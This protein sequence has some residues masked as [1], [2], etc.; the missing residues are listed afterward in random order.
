MCLLFH[1][2]TSWR[3]AHPWLHAL[4]YFAWCAV[5]TVSCILLIQ[6]VWR[7]SVLP[8]CPSAS[9]LSFSGAAYAWSTL[10]VIQRSFQVATGSPPFT[11][12]RD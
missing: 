1:D 6:S 8:A 10:F 4:A 2:P 11:K 7:F 9:P 5:I 3:I 12:P